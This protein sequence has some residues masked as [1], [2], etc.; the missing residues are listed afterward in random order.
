MKI[1]GIN[2]NPEIPN[3]HNSKK[4]Q[5]PEIEPLEESLPKDEV[6]ISKDALELFERAK[7]I[8]PGKDVV[9][10]VKNGEK[11]AMIKE[12][13]PSSK[14]ESVIGQGFMWFWRLFTG[15]KNG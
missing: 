6:I 12:T 2:G 3:N 11:E 9:V 7:E 1:D 15:S 13:S 4:I 8:S 14:L 10:K 5:Q